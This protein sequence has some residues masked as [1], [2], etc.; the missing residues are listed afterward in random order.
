[1]LGDD[2][3]NDVLAA[4]EVGMTGVLVKTGKFREEDLERTE[5]MTRVIESIVDVRVLLA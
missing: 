4:Q 1:M 5:A 3:A 2:V